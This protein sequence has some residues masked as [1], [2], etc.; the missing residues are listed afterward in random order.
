MELFALVLVLGV[1]TFI[2]EPF[3][4]PANSMYPS[5]KSGDHVVI[6]KLG[7]GNYD[8]FSFDVLNTTLH[9]TVEGGDVLA[10]DYPQNP[11]LAYIKRVIGLPGDLVKMSEGV[12]SINGAEVSSLVTKS[13]DRFTYL[14]ESIGGVDYSI[15]HSKKFETRNAASFNMT[16]PQGNCFMLGDNRFNSNDS[17]Y[18]GTVPE[19]NLIGKLVFRMSSK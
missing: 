3:H 7:Y 2:A 10:F 15:A 12:I 11:E 1:R 6:Y 5:L 13:D 9:A 4:I 18:W 14:T 8:L 19:E 17:R 16:V